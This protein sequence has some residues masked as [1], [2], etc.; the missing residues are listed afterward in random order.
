MID[1]VA[2]SK[3]KQRKIKPLQHRLSQKWSEAGQLIPSS[4]QSRQLLKALSSKLSS[5]SDQNFSIDIQR[6]F[7]STAFE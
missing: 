2:I 5:L 4:A 1:L 6:Q 3:Q 7:R